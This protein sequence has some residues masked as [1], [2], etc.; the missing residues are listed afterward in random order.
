MSGATSDVR[1]GPI[2]DILLAEDQTR[3][4]PL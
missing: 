2:A 1:F 3:S 4:A